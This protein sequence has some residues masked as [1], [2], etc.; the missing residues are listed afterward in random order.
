M[1]K[2]CCFTESK[3]CNKEYH[4]K[5]LCWLGWSGKLVYKFT[6]TTATVLNQKNL[7]KAAKSD[8]KSEALLNL[9]DINFTYDSTSN[10]ITRVAELF[11]Q[12]RNIS[13][14]FLV[15]DV[16]NIHHWLKTL[17]FNC[18]YYKTNLFLPYHYC[19]IKQF[20]LH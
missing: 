12:I 8:E 11:L 16:A 19:I 10:F 6:D 3:E 1:S 17:L 15:A 20:S 13:K 5:T 14:P 2:F 18:C 4:W 7:T 9:K